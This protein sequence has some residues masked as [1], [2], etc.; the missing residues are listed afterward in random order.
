[1]TLKDFLTGGPQ[2]PWLRWLFLI[3]AAALLM[4]LVLRSE[5]GTSA[6]FYVLVPYVVGLLIYLLTPQ[7]AGLTKGKRAARHIRSAVIVML[8]SSAILMEGFL[9]VIFAFPIYLIFAGVVLAVM[10]PPR[11]KAND[12]KAIADTFRGSWVPVLVV[13][14]SVEG[15]SPSLSF[16]RDHVVTRTAVVEA[17]IPAIH[18]KLA[19]P[20]A[21]TESPSKFLSLFPLP[22]TVEAGT[23]GVGDVHTSHYTYRR[24]PV[25][26]THE[27]RME[28]ELTEVSPERI[29]TTVLSND[30]YFSHY[31][32]IKGT[33]IGL[34]PLPDGRTEVALSI[35]Y[36]RDLDPAWYFGPMQKLAMRQSADYLIAQII[37]PDGTLAD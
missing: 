33:E 23:L 12:R 37:A 25:L 22:H 26:N 19:E 10:P 35:H 3:G 34:K 30:A 20:I 18:A 15:I 11:A 36:R 4:R 13:A 6:V 21:L 29:R 27:G 14:M 5:Y 17:G 8:A 24:W 16:E 28:V 32:T 31:M 2:P 7:P 9:C 1:M